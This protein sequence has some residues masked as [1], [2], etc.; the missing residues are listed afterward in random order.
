MQFSLE[1]PREES[2]YQHL[3]HQFLML[4]PNGALQEIA[5]FKEWV[6]FTLTKNISTC[7]RPEK[8]QK[9]AEPTITDGS[10]PIAT[11]NKQIKK[12]PKN[13]DLTF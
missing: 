10:Q 7:G 3:S 5:M 13:W 2:L 11:K 9:S 8:A 1:F 4:C 12:K 6:I